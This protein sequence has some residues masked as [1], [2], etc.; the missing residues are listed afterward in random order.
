MVYVCLSSIVVGLVFRCIR[1]SVFNILLFKVVSSEI[2]GG[3][4]LETFLEIYCIFQEISNLKNLL[5]N[6]AINYIFIRILKDWYCILTL[7]IHVFFTKRIAVF[8]ASV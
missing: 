4:F 3:K 6:G 2:C 1:N 7:V 5:N 8:T